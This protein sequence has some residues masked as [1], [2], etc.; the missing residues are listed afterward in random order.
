MH[1]ARSFAWIFVWMVHFSKRWRFSSTHVTFY[2]SIKL[3]SSKN[4]TCEQLRIKPR[5][6]TNCHKNHNNIVS[7]KKSNFRLRREMQITRNT[8][9]KWL[10][11]KTG[12]KKWTGRAIGKGRIY[13]RKSDRW[14]VFYIEAIPTNL[15]LIP[16]HYENRFARTFF[17]AS[18]SCCAALILSCAFV[19]FASLLF[20]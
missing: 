16:S 3:L 12:T 11:I 9:A 7:S 4:R 6:K 17:S 18:Q 20:E 15:A 13:W 2:A 14:T 5:Y 10:A 8:D 19:Q 1:C